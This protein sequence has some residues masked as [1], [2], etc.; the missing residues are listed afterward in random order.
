MAFDLKSY[1]LGKQ[2]KPFVG[3]YDL[4]SWL[5][6][7]AQSGDTKTITGTLP[8]YVRSRASQILEN[9]I[10]YGTAEGAGAE[11]ESGEPYGYKLPITVTSNGT[12][13]DYPIYI[14]GSKLMR[15]PDADYVDYADYEKGKI[16]R[17]INE[18]VLTGNENWIRTSNGAYYLPSASNPMSNYKFTNDNISINSH[19]PSQGMVRESALVNDGKSAFFYAQGSYTREYYIAVRDIPTTSDFKAFLAD[20]YAAGT[21][22]T[23]WYALET[24]IEEDPPIPFPD[25]AL[26]RATVTID[27]EEEAKPQATVTGRIEQIT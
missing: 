25:I 18:F 27:I 20:Q 26:P 8:L 17:Q 10:I 1:L 11:T 19:F 22:V 7:K 3:A 5:M 23:V 4:P 12:T 14:G 16:V 13:I 6:G 2:D 21:P 24:P 15:I 9:Y